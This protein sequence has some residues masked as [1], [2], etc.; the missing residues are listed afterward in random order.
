MFSHRSRILALVAAVAPLVSVHS[1][2]AEDLAGKH[3][4][5]VIARPIV[6]IPAAFREGRGPLAG[7][8]RPFKAAGAELRNA[9]TQALAAADRPP[10]VALPSGA[11]PFSNLRHSSHGEAHSWRR[12][13]SCCSPA[14]AS[15]PR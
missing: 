2:R 15:A 10:A 6:R 12:K 11:R 13:N 5:M 4:H 1:L 14:T 7:G 9:R 8:S 3:D